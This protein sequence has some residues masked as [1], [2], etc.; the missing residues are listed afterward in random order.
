ML[1]IPLGLVLYLALAGAPR[2]IME[3]GALVMLLAGV[4]LL[5]AAPENPYLLASV[6]VWRYGHFL[7]FN[8]LTGLVSTAWPFLA[9]AYLLWS[10]AERRRTAS[11][12]VV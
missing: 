6:D 5:N 2:R 1:G 8:G 4:A 9:G 10:L 3:A 11:R 7:S 12:E